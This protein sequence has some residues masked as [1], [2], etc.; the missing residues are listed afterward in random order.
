MR[1]TVLHLAIRGEWESAVGRGGPYDRSTLGV[2][3]EQEGYI[4]CSFPDQV[5][6]TADRYY[7]GRD[8]V[9]VL[10]I[11]TARLGVEVR[12]E[13]LRDTGIE[14]PHIYGPIP[15]EAVVEVVTVT[16]AAS[17]ST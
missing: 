6:A 10:V 8:D 7:S 5:A 12:V 4:H 14:F 3:L 13:D 9:V 15:I 11:D 16:E 1:G 17:R 2:S